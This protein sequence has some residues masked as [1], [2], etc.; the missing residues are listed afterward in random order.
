MAGEQSWAPSMHLSLS[1]VQF[2]ASNQFPSH[3]FLAVPH[4]PCLPPPGSEPIEL[5]TH[6]RN[7]I[8]YHSPFIP[9]FSTGIC[10]SPL[11]PSAL[12]KV[13]RLMVREYI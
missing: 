5:I 10:T 13:D 8:F 7:M 1:A 12:R 6:A 11:E 4:V 2:C 3:S 9:F